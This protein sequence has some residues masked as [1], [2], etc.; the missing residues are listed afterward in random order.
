MERGWFARH[1]PV[2][3]DLCTDYIFLMVNS[4]K[5]SNMVLKTGQYTPSST[6]FN[7]FLIIPCMSNIFECDILCMLYAVIVLHCEYWNYNFTCTLMM[8]ASYYNSWNL[9]I[10]NSKLKPWSLPAWPIVVSVHS[11]NFIVMLLL[12]V[13][14]DAVTNE[15]NILIIKPC[16]N[17]WHKYSCDCV[18]INS[19]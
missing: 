9:Y 3:T 1:S 18:S 2:H 10:V 14:W 11:C 6:C 12:K 19:N 4:V 15:I 7:L 17:I 8:C 16:S 5:Y 13:E